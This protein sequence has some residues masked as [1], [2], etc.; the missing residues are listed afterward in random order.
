MKEVV[1]LLKSIISTDED[2]RQHLSI[3][4]LYWYQVILRFRVRII[5]DHDAINECP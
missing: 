5:V 3:S 4:Y 2:Q 1:I